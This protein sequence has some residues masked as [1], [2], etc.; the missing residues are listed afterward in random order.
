M[1]NINNFD[2]I[3]YGDGSNRPDQFGIIIPGSRGKLLATLYT[4]GGKGLHPL[5]LLFHGMPGNEQNIDIAQALRREGFHVL[6]FHYSGSWG[7]DG[8]YSLKHNL[9]DAETVLDFMLADESYGIDQKRIYAIGHSLGGFVC[10][11][12]SAKRKEITACALLMPCDIGRFYQIKEEDFSAAQN[13]YHILE[14]SSKWLKGASLELFLQEILEN[15]S[16]FPLETVAYPLAEKPVLCIEASLDTHTPPRYHCSPLEKG[17][18]AAGG[19]QLKIHTLQTDHCAADY[20]LELI[21]I[22]T[23]FFEKLLSEKEID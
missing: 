14:E 20:R 6:T 7:S 15:S 2:E 13:L 18:L 10:G 17:I 5:I 9:E 12:L 19:R 1:K 8:N 11:Q 21:L 4:S 22:V 3:H 23:G 16:I